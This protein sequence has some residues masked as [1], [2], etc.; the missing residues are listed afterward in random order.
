[1]QGGHYEAYIDNGRERTGVEVFEWAKRVYELGAGEILITSIDKEG[2]G[3]GFDLALTKK[4]AQSVPI[5]VIACGG[6]GKVGDIYDVLNTGKADAV[7]IASVL[8]Y[9][10]VKQ[11]DHIGTDFDTGD[12]IEAEWIKRDSSRIRDASLK[13][14]KQYLTQRDLSCRYER[15]VKQNDCREQV[16]SRDH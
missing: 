16:A 15:G 9:N 12:V 8:H 1:M 13:D 3:Q 14:I 4:I 11:H 7:S 6:A 10:F 5:P 2:T